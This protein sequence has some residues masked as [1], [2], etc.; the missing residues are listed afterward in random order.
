MLVD[1][2]PLKEHP[3]FSDWQLRSKEIAELN[4]NQRM[5]LRFTINPTLAELVRAIKQ[6]KLNS[7]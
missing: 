4:R 7:L 2:V 1:G 3:N 5:R 6:I